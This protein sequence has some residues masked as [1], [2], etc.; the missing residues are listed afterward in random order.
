MKKILLLSLALLCLVSGASALVVNEVTLEPT[1]KI[2]DQLLNLNGYGLRKKFF[3]PIYLGSFYTANP[4]TT[5]EQALSDPGA[6]LIRMQFIYSRADY[7]N[8]L[9]HFAEGFANNSPNLTG[10]PEEKV[11]MSW[12]NGDFLKGD[13][14]DFAI[15]RDG[16]V[17]AYHNFN[18]LGSFHSPE[19][20]KGILL[21]YLG[22]KPASEKLKNALLQG[23]S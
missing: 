10:S 12:F 3:I 19:L 11:F 1:A 22:R 20:A 6:K 7:L 9:G 8:V 5:A 17:S 2:G 4:V 23:H 15:D 16:T 13:V 21:I 14:V 18:K